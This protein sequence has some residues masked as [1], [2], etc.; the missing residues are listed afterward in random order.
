MQDSRSNLI[1]D[2]SIGAVIMAVLSVIVATLMW[3][4]DGQNVPWW[5]TARENVW[6]LI[7]AAALSGG[8]WST[9]RSG[10]D[11]RTLLVDKLK[12][13]FNAKG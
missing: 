13:Y 11:P 3:M 8:S 9:M 2:I 4:A 6:L 12:D 10:H 7:L 5:T 1:F